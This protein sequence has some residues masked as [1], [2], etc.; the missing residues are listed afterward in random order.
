M[1]FTVQRY[2]SHFKIISSVKYFIIF[3][4]FLPFSVQ[5]IPLYNQFVALDGGLNNRS[6]GSISI[7][8]VIPDLTKENTFLCFAS[9]D[10]RT[11]SLRFVVENQ[12]L[13]LHDQ[14]DKIIDY[15]IV[16]RNKDTAVLKLK[17]NNNHISV[18]RRSTCTS[19]STILRVDSKTK[20]QDIRGEQLF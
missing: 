15:D 17:T 18:K 19:N 9:F 11:L 14:N 5:S 8:L 1:M 2:I 7:R 20:I 16:H 4:V 12:V 13:Y 10:A 6:S 3:S